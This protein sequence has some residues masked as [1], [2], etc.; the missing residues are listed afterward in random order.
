MRVGVLAGMTGEASVLQVTG[1]ADA[2]GTLAAGTRVDTPRGTVVAD[3]STAYGIT[4][5]GASDSLAGRTR[6]H[7]PSGDQPQVI[8]LG[9]VEGEDALLQAL[10]DG[11]IDAVARGHIGN[12][13]ASHV[14]NGR[15]V[16]AVVDEAFELG[17]FTVA[18]DDGELLACLN[19]RLD[20]LTANQRIGYTEWLADRD[21][22][23]QRARQWGAQ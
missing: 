21:V 16:V 15:L 3:G 19:E 14:S 12:R 17:G 10:R 20:Y 2:D 8:Y 11:A 23:L 7:P 22:F 13:D 4:A 9:D 18:V 1:L 6:L 5:A